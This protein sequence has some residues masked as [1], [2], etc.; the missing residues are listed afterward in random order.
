MMPWLGKAWTSAS[1]RDRGILGGAATTSSVC[2]LASDTQ[3][4]I[5][6]FSTIVDH[7]L[8]A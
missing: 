5:F 8:L 1:K 3:W 6:D 4:Q 2:K 7:T